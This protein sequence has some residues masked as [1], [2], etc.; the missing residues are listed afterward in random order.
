MEESFAF[1]LFFQI[2]N[3]L[4]RRTDD[5]QTDRRTVGQKE[6]RTEEQHGRTVGQKGQLDSRTE[7]QKENWTVGHSD[8]GTLGQKESRTEGQLDRMTNRGKDNERK[9]SCVKRVVRIFFQ[10]LQTH[11]QHLR[12]FFHQKLDSFDS[13]VFCVL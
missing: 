7:G 4:L 6:R 5:G 2:F 1:N 12:Q 3:L 10:F 9:S 8:R 13:F 11:T